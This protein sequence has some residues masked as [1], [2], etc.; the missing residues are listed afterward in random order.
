MHVCMQSSIALVFMV[1]GDLWRRAVG[2]GY[3]GDDA[4]TRRAALAGYATTMMIM[5]FRFM[6]V[7]S[8]VSVPVSGQS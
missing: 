6:A 5:M 7:V 2:R 3:A 4:T 1:T 8:R